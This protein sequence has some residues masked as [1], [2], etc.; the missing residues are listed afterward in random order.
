M[1]IFLVGKLLSVDRC[2]AADLFQPE[3]VYG[4]IFRAADIDNRARIWLTALGRPG[5][6]ALWLENYIR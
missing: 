2:D 3:D 4:L 5:R 6:I 1:L